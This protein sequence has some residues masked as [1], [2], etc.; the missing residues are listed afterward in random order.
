MTGEKIYECDLDTTGITDYGVAFE[1]I[2]SGQ[3]KVPPGHSVFS[4]REYRIALRWKPVPPH[5]WR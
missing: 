4:I 1:A 3:A 5:G 2:L